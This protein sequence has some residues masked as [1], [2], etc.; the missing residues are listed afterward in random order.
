[1]KFKPRIIISILIVVFWLVMVYTLLNRYV[2]TDLPMTAD[3]TPIKPEALTQENVQ[4]SEWMRL[5]ANRTPIGVFHT[6]LEPLRQKGATGYKGKMDLIL[7]MGSRSPE[8]SIRGLVELNE[9]LILQRL[10][11]VA[12]LINVEW[13]IFG[14]VEDEEMTYL[15]QRDDESFVGTISIKPQTTL[16]DSA[17]NLIGRRFNL[18]PGE[19]YRISVFDPLWNFNAGEMVITVVGTENLI[20][21]NEQVETYKL[22]TTLGTFRIVSWV[23]RDGITIKRNIGNQLEMVKIPSNKAIAMFPEL[24]RELEFPEINLNEL[25][26][27]AEKQKKAKPWQALSLIT[28]LMGKNQ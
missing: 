28:K 15:M 3:T 13:K 2:F 5:F 9:N 18:I 8:I 12:R 1:M 24:A 20:I 19:S 17:N 26:Q 23:T 14:T 11:V 10:Y 4:Y 22:I 21:D 27:S 7:S 25:K 16:L 6:S